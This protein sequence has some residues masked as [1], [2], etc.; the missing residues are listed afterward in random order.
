[1][2]IGPDY[3][4]KHEI[5]GSDYGNNI[6]YNQFSK[7]VPTRPKKKDEKPP[8]ETS[9][10]ESSKILIICSLLLAYTFLLQCNSIFQTFSSSSNNSR[11]V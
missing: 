11:L 3:S 1:M 5:L 2:N 10:I 4:V 7:V 6:T 8:T 9:D